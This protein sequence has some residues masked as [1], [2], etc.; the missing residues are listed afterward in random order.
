[1]TDAFYNL[2]KIIWEI[3]APSKLILLTFA[4]GI[5]LQLRRGTSR[6]GIRLCSA[7]AVAFLFL[8]V[9]PVGSILLR[10]LERRFPALPDCWAP[11]S[12]SVVIV[13]LGGAMTTRVVSGTS[14]DTF[15]CDGMR[16]TYAAELAKRIPTA[17]IQIAGGLAYPD[18]RLRPEAELIAEM[19]GKMGIERSRIIID[20]VSRTTA[21]NAAMLEGLPNHTTVILVTSAFHMPRAVGTFRASGYDVVPAPSHWMVD[22]EVRLSTFSAAERLRDVDTATKEI[23]GLTAYW[24]T[25]RN[26][27]LLPYPQVELSCEQ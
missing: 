21:E 4:L 8:G 18:P 3:L 6:W 13:V 14:H 23:M 27:S 19:L 10:Q 5:G 24:L 2:S 20:A 22:D 12:G 16:I 15:T 9:V 26:S 17:R 7:G 25:G 11:G 1:M